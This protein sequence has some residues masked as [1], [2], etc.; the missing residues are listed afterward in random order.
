MDKEK[1]TELHDLRE[2]LIIVDD[3]LKASRLTWELQNEDSFDHKANIIDQIS[4]LE[5]DIKAQRVADYDGE[6]KGKVFGVGIRVTLVVDDYDIGVAFMWAE[7]HRVAMTLDVPP[8]EKC[9]KAGVVDFV[10]MRQVITATIATDLSE[11]AD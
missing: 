6:D 4:D 7:K 9:V 5:A 1:V 10:G 3:L 8:F 11:W 2:S